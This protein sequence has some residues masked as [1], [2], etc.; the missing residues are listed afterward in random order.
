MGSRYRCRVS[1]S[2]VPGCIPGETGATGDGLPN[3][4]GV[5]QATL[6]SEDLL[7]GVPEDLVTIPITLGEDEAVILYYRATVTDISLGAGTFTLRMRRDLVNLE[8]SSS[9]DIGPGDSV[10]ISSFLVDNPGPG[11]YDYIVE[12]EGSVASF[13]AETVR[14]IIEVVRASIVT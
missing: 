8:S 12:G 5:I 6:L 1:P 9:G 2:G 4:L 7:P 13:T 10:T 11:D 3:L 14:L